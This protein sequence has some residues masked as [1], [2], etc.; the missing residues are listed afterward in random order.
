MNYMHY[1]PNCGKPFSQ[2]GTQANCTTCGMPGT[3]LHMTAEE[4]DSAS[5][6]EKDNAIKNVT[7][8]KH[9]ENLDRKIYNEVTAM[10]KKVTFMF[11]VTIIS[12]VISIVSGI[13]AYNYISKINKAFNS[14]NTGLENSL[15]DYNLDD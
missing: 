8:T 1:C 14:F 7:E 9:S 6:F 4:W 3:Y 12:L 15:D 11:I 5:T 13:V 2:E 10:H